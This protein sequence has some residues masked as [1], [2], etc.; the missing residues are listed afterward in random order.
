M[1][2][3]VS[4]GTMENKTDMAANQQRTEYEMERIKEEFGPYGK[5]G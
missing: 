1:Y 5:F 3:S 4:I 2:P